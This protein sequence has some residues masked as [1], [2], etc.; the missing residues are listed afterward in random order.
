[1]DYI[2]PT[3]LRI[4]HNCTPTNIVTN[5]LHQ[6]NPPMPPTDALPTPHQLQ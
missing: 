2:T 4:L 6:R 3:Q 5:A 1:M